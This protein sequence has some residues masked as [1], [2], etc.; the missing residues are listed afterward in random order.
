MF[1]SQVLW[2]ER[3]L[4]NIAPP[5]L[6]ALTRKSHQLS[7][8]SSLVAQLMISEANEKEKAGHAAIS[9]RWSVK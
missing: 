8:N 7:P 6:I 5:Y 1:T 2:D 9:L 3:K 4:S